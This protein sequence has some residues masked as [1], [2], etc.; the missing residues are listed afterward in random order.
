MAVDRRSKR[1]GML[2]VVALLMLG[3]LG[4]RLWFLQGVQ[5]A[6]Y[7]SDVDQ[8]KTRTVYIPAARGR[9]VDVDGRVLADNQR[10]L[11]VTVDWKMIRNRAARKELFARLSGHLAVPPEEFE[12]RYQSNLYDPLLPLPLKEDVD[13]AIVN[14]L[15]ERSED[16][17]GVDVVEEWRRVYPYAPLASHVVGYLGALNEN[18]VDAYMARGYNRNERVGAFGVEQSMEAYLHGDWGKQVWEIDA[19]GNTVRLLESTAPVAGKDV[20][21]SIDLDIQQYAEQALEQQLR[22]R[23]ELPMEQQSHNG[24]NPKSDGRPGVSEN[25]KRFFEEFPEWVPYKAP[26]GSVVVLN[27]SNGQVIAMASYPTFDNR[28]FNSGIDRAKFDVLFPQSEDPDDSILVNRAVQGRYNL[29]SAIKPFIAWSAMHSG[30]IG[31]TEFYRDEGIYK[32]QTVDDETCAS[33]VRCEFKN[34]I[35]PFGE[36]SR[37]GPVSVEEAL[38][39]SSDAFFYRLGELFFTTPGK[40]DELKTDLEQFGFG[41]DSGIDLPYEWDGR[42]PD[43]AIKKDLVERGVLAEGEADHL[44]T[45]DYV[46]VSIGQGL[47]AATPLQ[48]A[49]AYATLANSG[50]LMRPHIVRNIFEPLTPDRAPAVADLD[51]AVVFESFERPEIKHQLEMPEEVL[52]PIVRGLTRVTTSFRERPGLEYPAGRYRQ[53]TGESLFATYPEDAIPVAGKTGTAQGARSYP[54]NDSSA[55]GA[56]SVDSTR[57]YTVVSYLEK[58]GY[59]AK[60]AA[61]VVKCVFTALSGLLELDPVQPSDPLDVNSNVA[62]PQRGLLDQQCLFGRE[63]FVVK[64]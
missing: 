56:F 8:A 30:I 5:A 55:F 57:P 49:N 64:D 46:Q 13:E 32:L 38:A 63:G 33:G 28:W 2:A 25:D 60:G 22:N 48:L 27:H 44:V 53:T 6:D 16:H 61:P 59:G 47:M 45:G 4:T 17:P 29:G 36:P 3:S 58:A 35:D 52:A 34:A 42:I 18:N 14:T 19:S 39:V 1:L 10:I 11:T 20:Q 7:Q 62:A 43:D 51:A 37:Y 15:L 26:A 40:R 50:F 54:W 24:I 9:I 12:R 31:S 41:A 21:L 23:R